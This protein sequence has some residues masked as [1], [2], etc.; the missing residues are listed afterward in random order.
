MAKNWIKGAVKHPGALRETAKRAG[1]IKGGEKLSSG[2]LS[3]LSA[4]ADKT[5][6]STLKKRVDLAKTFK[7]MKH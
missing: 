7:K 6:N 1:L 3:K 5:G 2:D 4:K